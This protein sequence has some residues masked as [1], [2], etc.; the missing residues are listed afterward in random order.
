MYEFVCVC[1]QNEFS[2]F[3]NVPSACI[4]CQLIHSFT[5]KLLL[6]EKKCTH[7]FIRLAMVFAQ[8]ARSS[9]DQHLCSH[10]NRFFLCHYIICL[11]F[12]SGL[13][14]KM[15]KYD[16]NRDAHTNFSRNLHAPL[17]FDA[18]RNYIQ[19]YH[20]WTKPKKKTRHFSWFA[21]KNIYVK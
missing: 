20:K 3:I 9:F 7:K 8:I 21:R 16:R 2:I 15:E 4:N 12:S 5:C 1:V 11:H 18:M 6:V 17:T 14:W 19:K 10:S 13:R